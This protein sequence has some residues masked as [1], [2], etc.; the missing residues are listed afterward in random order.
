MRLTGDYCVLSLS[1]KLW[2]LWNCFRDCL[3]SSNGLP[4]RGGGGS[5]LVDVMLWFCF[6]K[7][8]AGGPSFMDLQSWGCMKGE[9]DIENG[10]QK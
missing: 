10:R 3:L 1:P 9:S 8:E 6:D 2:K 4:L 7:R 5:F